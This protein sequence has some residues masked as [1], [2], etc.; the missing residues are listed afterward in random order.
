[1]QTLEECALKES[2]TIFNHG[3]QH[4][5]LCKKVK[6]AYSEVN[7]WDKLQVLQL[8]KTSNCF[9]E[10]LHFAEANYNEFKIKYIILYI[11]ILDL[12]KQSEGGWKSQ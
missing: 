3:G 11:S 10:S 9:E 7:S 6:F 12:N 4:K 5:Y 8:A 1:M 2:D